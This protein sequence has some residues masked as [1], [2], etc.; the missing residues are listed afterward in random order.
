MKVL[1]CPALN[2]T[3]KKLS[4]KIFE[5]GVIFIHL[6]ELRNGYK[7]KEMKE[8]TDEGTSMVLEKIDGYRDFAI[9][10]EFIKDMVDIYRK[11]YNEE[12][13]L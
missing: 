6:E 3:V 1:E 11:K 10:E 9:C 4:E 7:V 13:S 12:Y 2:L 5:K 8:T